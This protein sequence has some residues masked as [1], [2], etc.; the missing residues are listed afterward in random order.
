[1]EWYHATVGFDRFNGFIQAL[2]LFGIQPTKEREEMTEISIP[3]KFEDKLILRQATFRLPGH[4]HRKVVEEY[5]AA[6]DCSNN[7]YVSRVAIAT[8]PEGKRPKLESRL[9]ILEA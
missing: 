4:K 1:M 3:G 7:G 8:Y 6:I 9:Q 2:R 5:P